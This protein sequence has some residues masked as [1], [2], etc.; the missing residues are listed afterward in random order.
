MSGKIG[1]GL[2]TGY[3]ARHAQSH[4]DKPG[5]QGG[6]M[7]FLNVFP[8]LTIPVLIYNLMVLIGG[9]GKAADFGAQLTQPLFTVKMVSGSNFSL[10]SGDLVIVLALVLLFV[11]LIK[12]TGTS[13]GAI[14][15]HALS[16]VLFIVCL[17]EFL[18]LPGFSTA[19]FLILSVMTLLDVL[20]GVVVTIVSARRDVSLEGDGRR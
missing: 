12:S 4:S 14:I 20:A 2:A 17:I 3:A 11:E 9:G 19:T 8:V 6:V 15:N 18:L 10:G 7:G 5:G 1:R 16:M 13:A